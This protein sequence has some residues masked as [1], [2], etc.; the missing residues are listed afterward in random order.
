MPR[1]P[2]EYRIPSND[3]PRL[4]RYHALIRS[5]SEDLAPGEDLVLERESM[6]ALDDTQWVIMIDVLDED[7]YLVADNEEHYKILFRILD[8]MERSQRNFTIL[9]KYGEI[10]NEFAND[11][12]AFQRFLT[13]N[14]TNVPRLVNKEA[15]N[16]F[17]SKFNSKQASSIVGKYSNLEPSDIASAILVWGY[18]N[19][20]LARLGPGHPFRRM[21]LDLAKPVLDYLGSGSPQRGGK[22]RKTRKARKTRK[23]TRRKD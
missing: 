7:R 9:Y 3:L 18:Y 20:L 23:V 6:M 15:V 12:N 1:V 22:R 11:F 4:S 2:K 13:E 21:P 19:T 16:S 10:L 8:E 17:R 14:Q 5:L